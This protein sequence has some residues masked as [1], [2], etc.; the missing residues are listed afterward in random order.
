VK[1][2]DFLPAMG[3]G[4]PVRRWRARRH[5]ERCPRCAAVLSR[6]LATKSSLSMEVHAPPPLSDWE[7]TL[8]MRA[9][10][11]G[12]EPAQPRSRRLPISWPRAAGLA[13]VAACL[14]V[15]VLV[16]VRPKPPEVVK[17]PP[18]S[19]PREATRPE[20][21]RVVSSVNVQVIARNDELLEL[22]AAVER[23]QAELQSVHRRA[24][25]AQAQRQVAMTL[26]RFGRW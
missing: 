20:L 19:E 11:A 23:L 17:T 12:E 14:F 2:D 9:A 22:S 5:A 1:C 3:T 21:S 15:I 4:G 18:E 10:D 7:R 6:W 8:W 26:D 25:R 24:E 13:V 16:V